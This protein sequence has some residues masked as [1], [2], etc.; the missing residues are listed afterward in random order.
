[1]TGAPAAVEDAAEAKV[2]VAEALAEV[3]RITLV[4]SGKGGV[5][6]SVVAVNLAV[7][8]SQRGERVGLLDADLQGPSVAK[9]LGLRGWP[10]R[11]G[12]DE[13][14]LP[15][16]GPVGLSVQSLD[17][18]LEGNQAPDWDGPDAQGATFRSAMEEAALVDLL[19]RS[20]WGALDSL[21]IDLP[22]GADRLPALGRWLPAGAAALAVT[23]PTQVSLLAVERSLWRAQAAR[24]PLI[25]LVE[26][27]AA[28]ACAKCGEQTPLF[29]D[30][31]TARLARDQGVELLARIP[32]DPELA[33]T[34]DTGEVYLEGRGRT[35]PAGLAFAGLAE[36]VAT[37]QHP[38][39]EDRP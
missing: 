23:I 33:Q 5:G 18:F 28:I 24:I 20:R 32:F 21:V 34:A 6:K 39:L 9:L 25:G 22:P 12:S 19:G 15:A 10:V 14:V 16:P 8:L 1:V 30:G 31:G 11:V 17:F 37:Q 2:R 3:S 29:P 7:A 4:M 38:D 13:R 26:N 27:F 35:A 36:R